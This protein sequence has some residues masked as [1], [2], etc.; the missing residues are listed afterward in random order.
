MNIRD[1]GSASSVLRKKVEKILQNNEIALNKFTS[2][3]KDYLIYELNLHQA[4]LNIQNEEIQKAYLLLDDLKNDYFD[5]FHNAPVGYFILDAKLNITG[6]NKIGTQLIGIEDD[7]LINTIFSKY[8]AS[9]DAEIFHLT[10]KS[11]IS[12]NNKSSVKLN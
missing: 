9:E 12:T 3:E 8:I 6:V 4:E 2:E 10:M 5:L 1:N 11:A 7:K